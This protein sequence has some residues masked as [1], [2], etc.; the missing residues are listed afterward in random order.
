MVRRLAVIAVVMGSLA[1]GL[2]TADAQSLVWDLP[3]DGTWVRYEGTW[4]QTEV[5]SGESS[6]NLEIP[7]WTRNVWLK[8]VG[9]TAFDVR[10]QLVP[11]RWLEIKVLAGREKDGELDPG[12]TGLEL[13]K[14]LVPEDAVT[15]RPVDEAGVPNTFLPV[16]KG[17]RKLGRGEP[18]DLPVNAL[19]VYPVLSLVGY[20]RNLEK[21]EQPRDVQTG[22]GAKQ[23]DLYHGTQTSERPESRAIQESTVW[24]TK[25]V[26]F[27]VARWTA[28]VSREIKDARAPRS[29]FQPAT[30]VEVE[31]TAQ[32]TGRD[33]QSEL[34]LP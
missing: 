10:G 18:Q 22:L 32:E 11:A 28:K 24:R 5:G 14:I 15:G 17:Y 23:A 34:P 8:S 27:G 12:A 31:M 33:A 30:T 19:Q 3:E 16:L 9:K 1:F 25:D 26:P 21:S 4:K 29:E 13:Y 20:Y 2:P 6:L 7:P